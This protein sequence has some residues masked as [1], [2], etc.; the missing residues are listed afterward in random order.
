MKLSKLTVCALALTACSAAF[1]SPKVALPSDKH[2][3]VY[4]NYVTNFKSGEDCYKGV[5]TAQMTY[6]FIAE[7]PLDGWANFVGTEGFKKS[8]M[9]V[10]YK[11]T[12]G[13]TT[14]VSYLQSIGLT[15]Q[16]YTDFLKSIAA[17]DEYYVSLRSIGY[18]HDTGYQALFDEQYKKCATH[19]NVEP[20]N[21]ENSAP[22]FDEVKA[23]ASISQITW[24][25]LMAYLKESSR[26]SD[27]AEAFK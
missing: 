24:D 22:I 20:L 17:Y 18:D 16:K 14:K 6:G 15:E 21:A 9:D 4:E 26:A 5:A 19:F 7:L 2:A 1:A 27:F 8:G 13:G 10:F 12:V 23:N 3:Q 11:A 25:A